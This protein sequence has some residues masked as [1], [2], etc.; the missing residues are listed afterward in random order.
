[1]SEQFERSDVN[2]GALGCI[3][4]ILVVSL[5]ISSLAIALLYRAFSIQTQAREGPITVPMP[6]R[7]SPFPNPQLQ[8]Y[9]PE[10]LAKFRQKEDAI[11]NGYRW[12][13]RKAGVVG[14][15]IVLAMDLIVKEGKEPV[16]Q[17][18]G[19]TWV[20]MMQRRAQE[21]TEKENAR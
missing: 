14:I 20:E 16:T 15:P 3:G 1:M 5:I 9:P 4:L 18:P 21:G 7:E 19:P 8:L 12:V 13:D 11:L 10:D 2:P 6:A 17:T